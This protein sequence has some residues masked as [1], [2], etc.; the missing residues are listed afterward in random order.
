MGDSSIASGCGSA[1]QLADAE[2]QGEILPGAVA[3]AR[4]EPG[5]GS[6]GFGARGASDQGEMS[7]VTP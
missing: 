6:R 5:R 7:D 3:Q 4:G 1:E 2:K